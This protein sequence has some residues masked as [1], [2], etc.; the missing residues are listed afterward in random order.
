M[1]KVDGEFKGDLDQKIWWTLKGTLIGNSRGTLTGNFDGTLTRNL[2][3][4]LMGNFDW[5]LRGTLTGN[6]MGTLMGKPSNF[7]LQPFFFVNM[8]I[9]L[10]AIVDF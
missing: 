9:R 6:S 8:T 10:V 4:T 3:R 5:N 1:G 2:L 7:H